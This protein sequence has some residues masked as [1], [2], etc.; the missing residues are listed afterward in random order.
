ME[1]LLTGVSDALWDYAE[2]AFEEYRSVALFKDTLKAQG[3]TV[4]DASGGIETAFCAQY[5]KGKPVIGILAEYDA[6]SGLSQKA[7]GL[8]E[9]PRGGPDDNGN[10]HGCGHNLLGAGSLGAALA[11]KEYLSAHKIPGTLKLFGCPGEEG[12][13]GKAF[14]A[15]AGVFAGLDVA[16][17][18]HPM[19]VNAIMELRFL[20]NYQILYQFRGKASHAAASPHLGRSAL[21]AV[22]LMNV[23]VNFLREHV[24]PEARI[25]YAITHTGGFSPN[26]VQ[27]KAEVLYLIRAPGQS[28]VEE[29][30]QRVNKIA[31]GAAL[32]TETE[33]D[34]TFI[35][36]C[37]NVI[38]NKTL[39]RLLYD[40]LKAQAL[41]EY[42]EEERSFA[43]AL[44]QSSPKSPGAEAAM[45]LST[46]EKDLREYTRI[47]GEKRLCDRVLPFYDETPEPV[48]PGSSDVGDVSW[49]VP[50]A[51][52]ATASYALGTAEHSWQLV[53]QTRSSLGHK[54]LILAAK[55][56][57]CA[58]VEVLEH[59]EIAAKAKAEWEQ[60]LEGQLYRCAIPP[61]VKPRAIS[62]L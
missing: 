8:R 51:Q 19:A 52:I 30:Y 12:G 34:I 62:K 60:R 24:I 55:V 38:P 40:A 35:K 50:T 5:G 39:G 7:L 61:E 23:G 32:M 57:A 41:P 9:E 43:A 18:W 37:S 22:E 15:R 47:L 14:M 53:S 44:A 13:S 28:Q 3:F 49:N 2:T 48:F 46:T 54:G 11:V 16:F 10:G 25:H 56:I 29:I 6:L 26:V 20:A 45:F 27:P 4:E 17:S 1:T 36:A 31:Q 58:C 21:D 33:V 59:P 42:T